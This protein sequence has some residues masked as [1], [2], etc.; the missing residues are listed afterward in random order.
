MWDPALFPS[1]IIEEL[2]TN[3]D[4]N[5]NL[6]SLLGLSLTKNELF[7]TNAA[8]INPDELIG[9][10]RSP[11]PPRTTSTQEFR[12][13]LYPRNPPQIRNIPQNRQPPPRTFLNSQRFQD[14]KPQS[15]RQGQ[16]N[17]TNKNQR[18]QQ[19]GNQKGYP[20]GQPNKRFLNQNDLAGPSKGPKRPHWQ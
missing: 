17:Y 15:S 6:K 14:T 10:A 7:R 5:Q 19:R 16:N 4:S 12:R 1:K 2:K 13:P 18:P 9:R 3:L 8:K 20:R 11:P